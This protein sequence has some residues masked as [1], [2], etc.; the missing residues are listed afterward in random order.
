MDSLAPIILLLAACLLVLIFHLPLF[1]VPIERRSFESLPGVPAALV[2]KTSDVT[3][4]R[5]IGSECERALPG[6]HKC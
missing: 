6:W 3:F 4:N 5:P 1:F 2:V